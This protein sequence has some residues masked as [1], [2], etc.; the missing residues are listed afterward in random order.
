MSRFRKRIT[1]KT[2]MKITSLDEERLDKAVE[3]C[4]FPA[5][6]L[7]GKTIRWCTMDVVDWLIDVTVSGSNVR[8]R[9]VDK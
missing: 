7:V 1:K 2:V 9:L 4:T 5:P 8:K 6:V 3:E